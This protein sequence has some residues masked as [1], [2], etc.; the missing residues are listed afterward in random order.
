MTRVDHAGHSVDGAHK[1]VMV[2]KKLDCL[3]KA[4]RTRMLAHNLRRPTVERADEHV[5]FGEQGQARPFAERGFVGSP[6]AKPLKRHGDFGSVPRLLR[7]LGDASEFGHDAF[8]NLSCSASRERG[9]HD[10]P[11]QNGPICDL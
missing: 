2:V 8:A 6:G 9:R 10:C 1:V 7:S 11:G 4:Q 5:P 3:R